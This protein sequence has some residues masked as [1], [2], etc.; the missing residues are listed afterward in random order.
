[1]TSIFEDI[2]SFFGFSVEN[3][4]PSSSNPVADTPD[5]KKTFKGSLVS[6][7]SSRPFPSSEINIQEPRVYEDSLAIASYL[8]DSKPVI[9]N[10]KFLDSDAGKRLIDFICGTAYAINGH[11]MKIGE[12]IFLF[13]PANVRIENNTAAHTDTAPLQTTLEDPVAFTQQLSA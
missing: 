11:M 5:T 9:V 2:K 6:A 4:P 13:T 7:P 10:L 8:R 3:A 12:N 1:M